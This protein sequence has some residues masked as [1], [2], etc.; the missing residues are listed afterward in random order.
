MSD[1]SMTEDEAAAAAA[2][3]RQ[4]IQFLVDEMPDYEYRRCDA[5]AKLHPER[6]GVQV[7]DPNDVGLC[8]VVW[9]GTTLGWLRISDEPSTEDPRVEFSA[10]QVFVVRGDS[11]S[12]GVA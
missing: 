3:V 4:A 11:Q 5:L 8:Q 2:N 9:Q 7:L 12:D 1:E 6:P 10:R